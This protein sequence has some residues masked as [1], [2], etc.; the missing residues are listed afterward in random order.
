[1]R[2]NQVTQLSFK[3]V[4]QSFIG[5]QLRLDV[6]QLCNQLSSVLMQLDGVTSGALIA[7]RDGVIGVDHTRGVHA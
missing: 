4:L 2:P 1:M 6:L 3:F 5:R 7:S